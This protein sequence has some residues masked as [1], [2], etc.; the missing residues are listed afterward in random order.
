MFVHL[1]SRKGATAKSTDIDDIYRERPDYRSAKVAIAVSD[2]VAGDYKFL[3]AVRPNAGK[4]PLGWEGKLKAIRNQLDA[5]HPNW[6]NPD[7]ILSVMN[8]SETG[9]SF[10][11]ISPTGRCR[12]I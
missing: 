3:K 8:G 6:D 10:C 1:E 5:K 9:I 4:Y 12:A 11:A 2:S 7:K